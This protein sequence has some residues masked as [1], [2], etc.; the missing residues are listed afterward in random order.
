MR[1]FDMK[2]YLGLIPVCARARRKQNRLTLLCIIFTVFLVT[3]VFS[4]AEIMV[5]SEEA[6]MVKKHGSHHIMISGISDEEAK[7]IAAAEEVE[8]SAWL[9]SF[10]EDIYEGYQIGD[11]RVVLYGAE[12]SYLDD[13]REYEWEGDFPRNDQEVMLNESAKERLGVCTGDNVTI[14]TPAGDFV[15]RVTGFCVDEWQVYNKKYDGVTAYMSLSALDAVCTANHA[16]CHKEAE[17]PAYYVRFAKGTN[18]RKAVAGLKERYGSGGGEIRENIVTMGTAG[19]SGSHAINDLYLTAAV[20]FVLILIA[21]GL[22]ISSCLNSTVSQ[23]IKFFGMMRCIGA[24]KKQVMHFVRLEALNWCKSAIPI[25]LG[26]SILVTWGLFLVLKYKIGGEFSD[27]SFRLSL[28][29]IVSGILVGLASVL[30]AANAPAKRAA[31]VSPMA[32]VSGNAQTG[33]KLSQAANTRLYKVESA[34]GVYHAAVSKKNMVLMSLSFAFTITLFLVFSAGLD[35]ARRLIPS[36]SDLNPDISIAAPDSTNSIDRSR[37][38]EMGNVPGV[39]A[40]FGC[41]IRYDVPAQINGVPGSVD[42]ISYDDYMFDWSGKSIVSGDREKVFGDT[43][44]VAAIYH[45]DSRL[46]TGDRIKV[47]DVELT[48][49]CVMSEGIGTQDRPAIVCTEETFFR[50]TGEADYMLLNAQLTKEAADETVEALRNL[51]GE[52]EFVDRR[53]DNQ[54]TKSSFWTIRLAVYGF[55]GIIVLITV[56]NIMNSISMSVSVRMKQYGIMR[57]VGMSVWQMTKMIAAEAVT[58]AV[59]GLFLGCAG[60][61]LL[62]RLIMVKIVFSHFGGS[63][64]VPVKSLLVITGIIVLSC[65]AAV[66]APAKRIRDMEV[67]NT[68]NEL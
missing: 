42:L 4:F 36:E 18:I 44:Y 48:V 59:C 28:I 16:D 9:R 21:G 52:N 20:V 33:K 43:N 58:Y 13:I 15:Y 34:L 63:W 68:I 10:G 46:N 62:H 35:L 66:R 8:A 1:T 38:E 6:V 7:E 31:G 26:V 37:K 53:E 49:A 25:G 56:F 11:K 50:M 12:L 61:L 5:K 30:L 39:E 24:S 22:M 27:L 29:G 40:V 47:G 32:A 57:A 51:A 17:E 2:S 41:A 19:V 45:M 64:S 65:I 14:R 60:G 55:L 3:T 23:R 54:D 67:A